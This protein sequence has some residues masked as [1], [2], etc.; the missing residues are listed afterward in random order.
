MLTAPL[1]LLRNA[2]AKTGTV[3]INS[4]QNQCA[5]QVS[6]PSSVRR[7]CC[8]QTLRTSH[9][10]WIRSPAASGAKSVRSLPDA[11]GSP[12]FPASAASAC[13]CLV[14]ATALLCVDGSSSS[15][16]WKS[17]QTHG[18]VSSR[19]A[20]G[21][22][23]LYCVNAGLPAG[24][25]RH[26]F[27]RCRCNSSLACVGGCCLIGPGKVRRQVCM[28]LAYC[29]PKKLLKCTA[30]CQ[31]ARC[32]GRLLQHAWEAAS[33][34]GQGSVSLPGADGA[35]GLGVVCAGTCRARS[36][37]PRLSQALP[38]LK[39]ALARCL[40]SVDSL[41]MVV[42]SSTASPHRPSLS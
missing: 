10:Q 18:S 37:W 36:N 38:R 39:N 4:E 41:S 3:C 16:C 34:S 30:K 24:R 14:L 23:L 21:K 12:V 25:T 29:T 20:E 11:R 13:G 32:R 9:A 15:A 28:E 22:H 31:L 40:G 35:A 2:P 19:G 33:R 7:D 17:W 42:K 27:A 8:A 6:L 26:Q 1:I 5:N